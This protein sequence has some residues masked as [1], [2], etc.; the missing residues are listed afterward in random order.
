[1]D[2]IAV[3]LGALRLSPDDFWRLTLPEL[4]AAIRGRTGRIGPRAGALDRAGLAALMARFPDAFPHS[5]DE[6][7]RDGERT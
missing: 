5:E 3:G 2:L 4:A 6:V 1:M 7:T